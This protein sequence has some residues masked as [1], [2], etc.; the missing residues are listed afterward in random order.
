MNKYFK[1]L[2]FCPSCRK[3]HL[4]ELKKEKV[5]IE[6]KGQEISYHEKYFYCENANEEFIPGKLMNENL[7][8]A[9]D[10]YRMKN[11]LLTSKQIKNIRQKYNLTQKDMA[12]L[13]GWG[14]KTITRYENKMIQNKAHDD[15]MKLLKNDPGYALKKLEENR[16][17]FDKKSLEEYK[18]IF[19]EK[20]EEGIIEKKVEIIQNAYFKIY[21]RYSDENE[22]NGYKKLN[23]KKLGEQI[24]YIVS[25]LKETFTVKLMKILWYSDFLNF[26]NNGKSISGLVYLHEQYGALPI[27]YEEIM[28]IFPDLIEI[29]KIEFEE[30]IGKKFLP[31]EDKKIKLLNEKEKQIIDKVVNKFKDKSGRELSEIMHEEIAYKKTEENKYISYEYAKDLNL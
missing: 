31:K 22:Y 24:Y 27:R 23:F 5:S 10:T 28:E 14:L 25:K 4:P 18:K 20:I 3:K 26:K 9:K 11:D 2:N 21:D 19:M 1:N 8:R 17:N 16:P 7:L 29:E 12:K 6:I 13:L 30:N 15:V